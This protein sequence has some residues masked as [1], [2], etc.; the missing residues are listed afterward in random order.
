VTFL[1]DVLDSQAVGRTTYRDVGNACAAGAVTGL[2]ISAFGPDEATAGVAAVGAAAL[3]C[4][5]GGTVAAIQGYSKEW[6]ELANELSNWWDA[7][8][9]WSAWYF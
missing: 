6:G 4:A 1:N 2:V 9:F 8:E 7:Y 5:V 3:G